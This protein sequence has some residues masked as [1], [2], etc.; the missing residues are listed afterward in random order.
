MSDAYRTAAFLCPSC[1]DA[2]LREYGTRLVCDACDGILL[3]VEE[4]ASQ[5]P[6]GEVEV[7]DERSESRGWGP[8]GLSPR[9]GAQP[10]GIVDGGATR[11]CPRCLRPMRGCCL[12]VGGRHLDHAL[13]RCE[14]DGIWF[15]DGSLTA[16]Y[17][18][19]GTGS[20]AQP[21]AGRGDGG[22]GPIYGGPTG[23]RSLVRRPKRPPPRVHSAPVPPSALQ[24][25]RLACPDPACGGRALRFEV[26]RWSCGG[27]EG[28]F[29]ENE[30]LE[31]LVG[32][33]AGR[34]WQ[35]P[36]P[37]GSPGRRRCPAC[38]AA[39]G[40]E[41]IEGVT[42]DRCAE[43]GVWFDPTELEAALQHAAG[44]DAAAELG[45]WLQR[46]FSRS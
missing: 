31:A 1:P 32:E 16:V 40:V 34:P 44:V 23:Q 45:S 30:A 33:M 12:V 37:E 38:A 36:P 28:V 5:V 41:Q 19:I 3:T 24:G 22:F 6:T 20:M 17:E 18:A 7:V 35:L 46:M 42:V 29:V 8:R 2:P 14:R 21:G 26:S 13:V 43:H 27:C 9:G 10:R 39:L 25:R 15:G 4:F 11:A